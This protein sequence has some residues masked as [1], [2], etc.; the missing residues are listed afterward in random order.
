M[1]TFLLD[2]DSQKNITDT[3]L[4]WMIEATTQELVS[5]ETRILKWL[6]FGESLAWSF[7]FDY[8]VKGKMIASLKERGRPIS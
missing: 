5:P 4:H 6:E 2:Y 8:P 3:E 1:A 7:G